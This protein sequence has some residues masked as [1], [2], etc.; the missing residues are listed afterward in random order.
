MKFYEDIEV[1]TKN[2][3]GRY[4]VT[5]EEVIDFASKYDPQPFHLDDEAAAQTHFGRLSASGW[6]T[7]SMTMAMMVEN[8]KDEKSAGLGSPGV[9]NLRW[10]KPVYPGDTL[11]CETEIIEK[12]RS[13][14]R[15][16][17]GI[18][19]SLIRTFNQN[20]DMVLEMVSNGLIRTREPGGSD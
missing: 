16:E 4:E 1:G 14:S 19:K 7:C 12:R 20:G 11:R 18:F 15:P 2:A 8:M 17:M 3:F 5:R 13:A 10:K 6:H 9:D